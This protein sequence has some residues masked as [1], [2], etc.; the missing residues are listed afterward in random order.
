MFR[1]PVRKPTYF[2]AY[3]YLFQEDF[4]KSEKPLSGAGETMP[5]AAANLIFDW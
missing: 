3:G 2:F 5:M 1:H 4:S